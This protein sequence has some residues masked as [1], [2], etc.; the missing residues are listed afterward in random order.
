M[1]VKIVEYF[2]Q[3]VTSE[4][5][6]M[7]VTEGRCP[8]ADIECSKL[9]QN[10]KP[11]C[12][13]R[14]PNDVLWIVCSERLCST[15]GDNLTE[16]QRN[17]LCNIAQEVLSPDSNHDE[18]IYKKEVGFSLQNNKRIVADYILGVNNGNAHGRGQGPN[19]VIVEMQGGGSTSSTGEMTRH[20]QNWEGNDDRTNQMLGRVLQK[21]NSIENDSW[22][23]QQ[24]QLIIKSHIA[25]QSGFGFVLCVGQALFEYIQSRLNLENLNDLRNARWDF[26][27]L[28]M[29]ETNR[30]DGQ[31]G[32]CVD[33]Q[34]AVYT[35][36]HNFVGLLTAQGTPQPDKFFGD[37]H[38]LNG[39]SVTLPMP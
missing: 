33:E 7:S 11:V 37:F 26:I 32:F 17:I 12:Y 16:Y 3:S 28:P 15:K 21:V 4:E 1:G 10:Y 14:K 36:F 35:T 2:G 31:V 27:L 20:V 34:N 9:V 39:D 19:R 22:K 6:I 23:R 5:P 8:F 13:M 29:I 38:T 25:Q 24:D 30:D 18:I